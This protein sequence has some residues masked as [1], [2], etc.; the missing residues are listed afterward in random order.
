MDLMTFLF[1]SGEYIPGWLTVL[2]T[3]YMAH[4]VLSFY[5]NGLD[6]WYDRILCFLC[7]VGLVSNIGIIV[8]NLTS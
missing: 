8:L 4:C 1:S 3:V 6:G 2:V 5:R 7:T